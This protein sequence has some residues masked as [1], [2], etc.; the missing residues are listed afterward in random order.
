M[1]VHR[2]PHWVFLVIGLVGGLVSLVL[3]PPLKVSDE[4][5]HF[6]R[7]YEVSEGKLTS[8][9]QGGFGG[10]IVPLSI[11][12]LHQAYGYPKACEIDRKEDSRAVLA[13]FADPLAPERAEF[14]KHNA[15]FYFPTVYAP[16]A[17]AMALARA[18]GGSPLA[19]LYA[20]RLATL[21]AALAITFL[22]IK[23]A[24]ALNWSFALLSLTTTVLTQRASISADS[25]TNAVA[26]LMVV[27]VLRLAFVER[28]RLNA[29]SLAWLTALS[30]VVALAK[31]SYFVLAAVYLLIPADK[32]DG[33]RPRAR[34]WAG[35]AL[36][37]G[38]GIAATAAWGAVIGP[39]FQNWD[40]FGDVQPMD[41]ARWILTNPHRYALVLLRT[42][43]QNGFLWVDQAFSRFGFCAESRVFAPVAAL[44]PVAVALVAA[45]DASVVLRLTRR[46]RL[47]AVGVFLATALLV[48]TA[49]Y[50]I[51]VRGFPVVRGVFGRYFLPIVPLACVALHSDRLKRRLNTDDVMPWLVPALAVTVLLF[52]A[53]A[54]ALRYW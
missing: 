21:L 27:E 12:E 45:L 49:L 31:Q 51:N 7:S 23:R 53:L 46:Q 42:L 14:F 40:I 38:S 41:Q 2:S 11:I 37:V 52:T 15:T 36:V 13:R 19:L 28:A 9:Q 6:V 4:I 50:A 39:L 20:G 24:P 34:Y 47:L 5:S 22:A 10:S 32:A 16:G 3:T 35:F 17:A 43:A 54:Q 48:I 25:L 29:R 8:V 1:R 33:P 26:L 30:V 44:A 18:L